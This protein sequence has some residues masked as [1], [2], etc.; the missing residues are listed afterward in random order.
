MF[1][2]LI[3]LCS[4]FVNNYFYSHKVLEKDI[5]GVWK[6]HKDQVYLLFWEDNK[7]SLIIPLNYEVTGQYK[8]IDTK[9]MEIIFLSRSFLMSGELIESNPQVLKITIDCDKLFLHGIDIDKLEGELFTKV[10]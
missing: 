6:H 7:M 1:I 4:C 8:F 5:I 3:T 2:L 10:H 9:T